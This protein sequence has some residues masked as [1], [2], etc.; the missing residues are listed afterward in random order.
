MAPQ[1]E[2]C[3]R[4]VAAIFQID[5]PHRQEPRVSMLCCQTFA[6]SRDQLRK[7]PLHVWKQAYALLMQPVCHYGPLELEILF[8]PNHQLTTSLPE[9]DDMPFNY[10]WEKRD[11]NGKFTSGMAMEHLA[12]SIYGLNNG[13]HLPRPDMQHWCEQFEPLAQCS[14]SPCIPGYEVP[15]DAAKAV[16][17]ARKRGKM[18]VFDVV[19]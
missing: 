14:S 7:R 18:T 4:D 17:F 12:P 2:Q 11:S 3:W 5:I 16:I 15:V 8:Y 19:Y 9:Y 1:F 6:A 10:D 13:L